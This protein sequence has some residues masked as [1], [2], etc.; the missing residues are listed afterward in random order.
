MRQKVT[1]VGAGNVGATAAQ[2]L[3]QLGYADVVLVDVVEDLP[4]GKSL[5]MAESGPVIGSDG[6]II[7]SNNYA[8]TANSDVVIITAGIARKPGMSRDDLLLTNMKITGAVTEEIVKYSPNCILIPVTNPLDAMV[9][10]ILKV[11]GFPRNRV[12]GMAGV[13]DS[14]RLKYFLSREFKVSVEDVNAFVLGGHG[15]TMVPLIRHSTISGIPIPELIKLKWSTN[16][17]I[18]EIIKRTRDGGAEIGKLMKTSSAFYAPA[19][20]AISMAESF[21][22]DQKRVLPCAAYLNGEYGVKGLYVGVPVIIGN[23]GVEKIIELKLNS[24]E[25]KQFQY[26]V[27]AVKKLS[28]LASKL[29]K[30]NK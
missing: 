1:V 28:K 21:I 24:A 7:G 10:N 17:K 20:S 27:N 29:I 3:H 2:R 23:K 14:A 22:R 9:H 26:S 12:L 18:N 4:Q 13:L 25:K 8:E 16:K 5:D 11:S 30:K 6:S 15:D 19:S